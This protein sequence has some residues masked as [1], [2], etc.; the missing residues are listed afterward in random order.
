MQ[1]LAN[2]IVIEPRNN[3]DFALEYAILEINRDDPGKLQ[4]FVCTN[5]TKTEIA[6]Q[7]GHVIGLWDSDCTMNRTDEI[8]FEV[9]RILMNEKIKE[10]NNNPKKRKM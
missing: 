9:K 4:L 7:T 8:C 6:F 5:L 3:D 10:K 1:D 2:N